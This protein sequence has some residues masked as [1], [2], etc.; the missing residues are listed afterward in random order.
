MKKIIITLIVATLSVT[1][2]SNDSRPNDLPPLFPCKITITQEG[3]PLGGA[4]V[5]LEP[6]GMENTKY[7]SSSVTDDTGKAVLCTYGFPGVPAGKYKVCV[8]KYVI[9][10]IKQF[11]NRDGELVND[12]GI[13]YRTVKA[14]YSDTKTTPHEIEITN[15]N[16][17]LMSFDVGKPIREKK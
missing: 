15:K 11:T 2:C 8:V 7:R 10:D 13:E 12:D 17:P 1:G 6:Q 4:T 16:T 14:L 3:T 5:T 9:E